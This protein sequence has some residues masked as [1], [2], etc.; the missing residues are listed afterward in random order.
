VKVWQ[1]NGVLA[2]TNRAR[3]RIGHRFDLDGNL[4]RSMRANASLAEIEVPD[5]EENAVERKLGLLDVYTPIEN[6]SGAHSRARPGGG[7]GRDANAPRH[8]VLARGGRRL[9]PGP[10]AVKAARGQPHPATDK[11]QGC[12]VHLNDSYPPLGRFARLREQG[13]LG[14]AATSASGGRFHQRQD[15]SSGSRNAA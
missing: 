14:G 6:A 9:H 3:D 13:C 15:E 11:G 5:R 4:G 12:G 1:Q 8:P 10:R 2:W 7:R